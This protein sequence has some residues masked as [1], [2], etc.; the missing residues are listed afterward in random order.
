[1]KNS[2][3]RVINSWALYDFANTIFSLNVVSLYFS[4]WL[5]KDLNSQD[6]VYSIALSISMLF[7]AI[8]SPFMGTLSDRYQKRIPFIFVFTIL[9]CSFTAFI[10]FT[11]SVQLSIFFF[12]VAN[13]SYQ[14]AL[15]FYNAL[16]PEISTKENIGK[17]SGYGTAIGYLG[18]IVSLIMIMPF[19]SG[20]ILK[21]DVSHLIKG[22][23]NVGAFI[24]TAILF[25]I[26]SIPLFLF[27]KD[28]NQEKVPKFEL[29]WKESWQSVY[30]SFLNTKKYNGVL[31]YLI[32]NFFF[33]DT[34]NTVIAFMGVYA[35]KVIGLSSEKNEIQTVILIATVTAVIGS[36]IFGLISDKI[37]SKKA[38]NL[39]LQLWGL[40]IILLVISPNK[41]IFYIS[42]MLIGIN[43]GG[44][45]ATSRPLLSELVP[46]E[47]Q[48]KFFGLYSLAGKFSAIFGPMIWG[49]VTLFA[50]ENNLRKV[51]YFLGVSPNSLLNFNFQSLK[52]KLAV[53][54]LLILLIVGYIILQKV[55]DPQKK[56]LNSN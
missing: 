3:W 37:G 39:T 11:K 1:M 22:W 33:F 4:L 46:Q 47:E 51:F 23:G 10:A 34:V 16:L 6:I 41:L 48:G 52:Y 2:N 40:A 56:I 25:F 35:N 36:Y 12:I 14:M 13:F 20:K 38:L 15:V 19:V 17:I 28:K 45:W 44:T 43:L 50:S 8:L 30:E 32:A 26:F 29:H 7:V 54:S 31:L 21:F 5:I 27:V 9:C 18:S 42:A 55:P 24:P 53:A 49:L